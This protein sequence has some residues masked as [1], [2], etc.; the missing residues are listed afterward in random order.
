MMATRLLAT[1]LLVATAACATAPVAPPVVSTPR[2]PDYPTPVIPTDLNPAQNTRALHDTGWLRL[3]A[4]DLARARRDFGEVLRRAPQFYPSMT[5]LGFAW[6]AADEF[7]AALANFADAIGVSEGYTPA[8]FGAAEAQVGLGR[9]LEAIASL[10]RL[11]ELDPGQDAL[12]SRIALLRLGQLQVLVGGGREA[13]QG[14]RLDEA[15]AQLRQALELSPSSAVVY[16]ELALVEVMRGD[17]SAAEVHARQAIE[18]DGL[19]PEA[20]AALGAALAAQERFGEASEAF[21]NAERLEPRAEWRDEAGRL[22]DLARSAA[23]PA[24]MR[25]LS[26][27]ASVTRAQVAALVALRLESVIASAPSRVDE[28]ATDIRGHWAASWILPVIRAGV[29]EIYPNHTFQPANPIARR[30]LAQVMTELVGLAAVGQ[31]AQLATWTAARPAFA[32]LPTTNV[33][34]DAAALAV[35]AGTMRLVDGDLFDP[36]GPV[37][38]VD[39][40]AAVGRIEDIAGR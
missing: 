33:F 32:D 4:G 5:G 27:A 40:L 21:V 7:G 34:Y 6:L 17:Y 20:L 9:P 2:F 12:R 16:R 31:A 24:E 10:E 28:V 22:R 3:Q 25:A 23:L 19:D 38:G 15:T 18:L 1:G 14:G 26:D 30:E 11:V 37:S 35:P 29:M 13:R 8:W 39:L 36:T